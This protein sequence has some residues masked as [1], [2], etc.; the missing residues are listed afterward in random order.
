MPSLYL[1]RIEIRNVGPV[2]ELDIDLPFSESH[3]IPTVFVGENGSGKSILLSHIVNMLV[4]A[5]Q[6]IY[7]DAEVDKGRVFKYRS[8]IYVNTG[9]EYSYSKVTLQNDA[10][11]SEIQLRSS[12]EEYQI[13]HG[14][15]PQLPISHSIPKGEATALLTSFA[16]DPD[17]VRD[18][19]ENQCCLYFPVN[20]FEEPA[21]LN[22]ENLKIKASYTD[23][24]RIYGR[25][26]RS[27]ICLSPLRDITNWI[28]DILLDKFLY[29]RHPTNIFPFI[30]TYQVNHQEYKG[31]A[32][33]IDN[34]IGKVLG[35]LLGSSDDLRLGI[36][37]RRDRIISI[38]KNGKPWIPNIFQLSTGEILL[39]NFFISIIRDYDN[40][41][42][43]YSD[44][45]DVCGIV[46]ID[47]IDAHLHVALQSDVLPKLIKIFPKVQF[48]ITSHSPL[49]LLGMEREFGENGIRIINMPGGDTLS[50]SDFSEFAV[51]YEAFKSTTKHRGE[52]ERSL[53]KDKVPMVFVEGSIDVRYI[54][55]AAEHLGRSDILRRIQL[56]E[57]NGYGGLDKIWRGFDNIIADRLY[58]KVILIYDCDTNKKADVRGKV[59]RNSVPLIAANPI[60][61][62][63]EN[64]L[65]AETIEKIEKMHPQYIDTTETTARSRGIESK[66]R[67]KSV[68]R[69][70][71][72]NL[73]SWLC[74][75]GEAEDFSGFS[76]IFDII[77]EFLGR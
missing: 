24:K 6:S 68:N 60:Q 50:A 72:S 21:W 56:E 3:P 30:N 31:P 2:R 11:I 48:I 26:N 55:K 28:L 40:S 12:R 42:S 25:S 62:G 59:H 53:E 43:A 7:D 9:A 51:A 4:I 71:K 52:I 8:P 69:D 10:Y 14:Q 77:E 76:T 70:E 36:G 27:I 13:K 49:F 23:L 75:F 44:I 46:V 58:A 73:C 22:L 34:S 16:A 66:T 57:S 45:K 39:L 33:S 41:G 37:N 20:R 32:T 15:L 1:K 38:M 17:Q 18:L 35:L 5:K 47:E 54:Q 74:E 29:E 67:S 65:S 64:L 61:K 19:F 63:I